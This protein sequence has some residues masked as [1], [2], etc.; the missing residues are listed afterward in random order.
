MRDLEIGLT[1]EADRLPSK[2]NPESKKLINIILKELHQNP[3]V[4]DDLQEEVSGFKSCK[5]KRYRPG[6]KWVK[7]I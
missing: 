3:C 2:L 1:P 5:R 4:R 6:L 7:K